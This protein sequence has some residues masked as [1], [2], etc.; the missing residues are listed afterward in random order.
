MERSNR[1]IGQIGLFTETGVRRGG[2]PAG[3]RRCQDEYGMCYGEA[4]LRRSFHAI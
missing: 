3:Y 1:D 4:D 2:A